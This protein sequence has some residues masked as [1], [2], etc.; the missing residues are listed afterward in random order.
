[1]SCSGCLRNPFADP[2]NGLFGESLTT[3]ATKMRAFSG[4]LQGAG[5]R[6]LEIDLRKW[7]HAKHLDDP[8]WFLDVAEIQTGR[9][10]VGK[11]ERLLWFQGEKPG[12]S[13]APTTTTTP[14]DAMARSTIDDQD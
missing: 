9:V 12:A 3:C 14:V 2:L 13:S 7:E 1:M 6:A 10:P 4:P 8:T 11:N 5:S